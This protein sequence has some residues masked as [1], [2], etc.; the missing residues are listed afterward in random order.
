MD[1]NSSHAFVNP[2]TTTTP[3]TNT[4]SD[5]NAT[6]VSANKDMAWEWGVQKDPLKKQNIWCTLCNKRVCGGI[7]RL[8]EHLTHTGGNVAACPN[9]TTEITKK[10]LESMK[11]KDKKKKERQRTMEILRSTSSIDLSENDDEQD[12]TPQPQVTKR[13]FLKKVAWKKIAV[14]AYSV[15]LPFNVV[16]D[17]GFQDVIN[18]IGEYGRGTPAPIYHNMQVTLLKDVLE[19]THN[20][21]VNCPTGTVFLKSIDASEHIH[22]AE[23]VVKKVNEVIAEVGEENVVQFITD[24][25]SNY[26]AA[27]NI[28]EEQHPRLF[29][30]PC[31]AHCVN[32]IVQ[33]IGKKEATIATALNEAR[34]I[35]VYIYNHGRI[36]NMMKKLT[37]NRELHR[38]CV[39]RFAT[40]FYT[41]QSVHENQHHVQVLFVSE[42]WRKSDFAKKAPGKKVEKIVSKQSFWDGVY[43]ACQIYAPLVDIVRLVDTEERPCMGY[44]YDAM[45]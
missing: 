41:L 34:A 14:W 15:G 8:K 39:T 22:N 12:D 2:P 38:S 31:A 25:G 28:F 4:R 27:G 18:A 1:A 32:L 21:L 7:T 10:V 11:E 19:D 42:Q 30:T 23:Y 43:L 17:E 6:S 33:D 35:V 5:A 9:V 26:K 37:K 45:S 44:I 36:L 16:C 29:W 24:N 40:Q 3:T 13:K 20:F